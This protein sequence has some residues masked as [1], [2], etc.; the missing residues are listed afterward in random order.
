MN[1]KKV[2][3]ILLCV[4]ETGDSNF[5]MSHCVLEVFQLCKRYFYFECFGYDPTLKWSFSVN[6]CLSVDHF[7]NIQVAHFGDWKDK[8]FCASWVKSPF[9]LSVP[10]MHFQ[11][12]FKTIFTPLNGWIFLQVRLVKPFLQF[13]YWQGIISTWRNIHIE[14][15]VKHIKTVPSKR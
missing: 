2:H 8:M 13:P 5:K 11:I 3:N 4:P 12:C 15:A 7:W 14:I 10:Y 9:S 6:A 1:L